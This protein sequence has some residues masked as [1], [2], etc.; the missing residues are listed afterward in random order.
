MEEKMTK[1][2]RSFMRSDRSCRFQAPT[3]LGR[4]A[5]FQLSP[6]CMTLGSLETA[7]HLWHSSVS[8]RNQ[9]PPGLYQGLLPWQEAP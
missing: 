3:A 4:T 8:R 9:D 1:F 6:S 2:S 7:T 5:L